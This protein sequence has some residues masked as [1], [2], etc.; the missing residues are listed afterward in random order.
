MTSHTGWSV[1]RTARGRASDAIVSG[2]RVKGFPS[3][4]PGGQTEA[5]CITAPSRLAPTKLITL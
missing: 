2:G 3:V 1:V 4:L 5:P